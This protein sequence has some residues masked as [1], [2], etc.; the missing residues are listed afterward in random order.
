MVG[1]IID[2]KRDVLKSYK[3]NKSDRGCYH[4]LDWNVN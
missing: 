3:V 1:K 2:V 4:A